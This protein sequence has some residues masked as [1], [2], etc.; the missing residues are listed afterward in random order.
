[1]AGVSTLTWEQR[2]PTWLI[3]GLIPTAWATAFFPGNRIPGER[4]PG[5]RDLGAR[6]D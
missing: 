5:N 2:K 4:V 6:E 1:V 3:F